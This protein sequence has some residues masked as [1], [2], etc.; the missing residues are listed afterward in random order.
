MLLMLRDKAIHSPRTLCKTF[1]VLMYRLLL[2]VY[3]LLK[4]IADLYGSVLWEVVY[5]FAV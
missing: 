1:W 2:S 4:A 5:P 3:S